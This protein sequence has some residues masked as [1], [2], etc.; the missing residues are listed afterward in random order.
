MDKPRSDGLENW[1]RLR[2]AFA[3]RRPGFKIAVKQDSNVTTR[4]AL[5][6]LSESLGGGAASG[7]PERAW[8][9]WPF[10]RLGGKGISWGRVPCLSRDQFSVTEPSARCCQRVSMRCW[11]CGE[12]AGAHRRHVLSGRVHVPRTV[13]VPEENN[14]QTTFRRASA[15]AHVAGSIGGCTTEFDHV[16]CRARTVPKPLVDQPPQRILAV[17]H[18]AFPENVTL[19]ACQAPRQPERPRTR[20]HRGCVPMICPPVAL[21]DVTGPFHLLK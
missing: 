3:G 17:S 2:R 16:H 1:V 14:R 8:R 21:G 9:G 18:L 19:D 7:K 4:A 20:N 5:R 12:S 6:H 15:N 10:V 11:S 13:A